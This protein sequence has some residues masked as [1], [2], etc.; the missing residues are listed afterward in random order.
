MPMTRSM[1][2]GLGR[3]PLPL[4]A[5]AASIRQL[6]AS[7]RYTVL[8][9]QPALHAARHEPV[10]EGVRLRP[11]GS[12]GQAVPRVLRQPGSTESWTGSL[13]DSTLRHCLHSLHSSPVSPKALPAGHLLTHLTQDP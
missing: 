1:S 8:G 7:R 4:P 11:Q 9:R 2:A 5:L 6:A 12:N 10:P 3:S 13:A